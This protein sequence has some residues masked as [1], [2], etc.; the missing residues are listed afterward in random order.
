MIDD[1]TAVPFF[2][3]NLKEGDFFILPREGELVYCNSETYQVLSIKHYICDQSVSGQS[4]YIRC[5][6]S[7]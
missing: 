2:K 4:I 7:E 1:S 5:T 6:K 3:I